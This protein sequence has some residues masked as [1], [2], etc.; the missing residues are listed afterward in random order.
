MVL[1]GESLRAGRNATS[2][3]SRKLSDH[4]VSIN[5]EQKEQKGD[6]AS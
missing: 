5:T 6:G 3:W 1:E 4:S 2:S